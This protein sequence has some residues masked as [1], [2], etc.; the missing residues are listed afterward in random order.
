MTSYILPGLRAILKQ[1]CAVTKALETFQLPFEWASFE[2]PDQD[3]AWP[4][5]FTIRTIGLVGERSRL[6]IPAK[7]YPAPQPI[8]RNDVHVAHFHLWPELHLVHPVVILIGPH[9][10]K[11]FHHGFSTDD[12]F[13][14]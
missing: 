10:P 1:F 7:L 12:G 13:C 3:H 4:C 2:R 8:Q 11:L 14:S 6:V 5:N 9:G